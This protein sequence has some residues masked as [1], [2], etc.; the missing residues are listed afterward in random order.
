MKIATFLVLAFGAITGLSI[1]LPDDIPDG[2]FTADFE[3]GNLT[4]VTMLALYEPT[5][6]AGV[7]NAT[8]TLP[9][10]ALPVT[11]ISCNRFWHMD[12]QDY[13]ESLRLI[14]SYCSLGPIIQSYRI[15]GAKVHDT[16]T[17]MCNYGHPIECLSSEVATDMLALDEWCNDHS[18]SG[19][20]FHK[21]VQKTYG[22]SM[23]CQSICGNM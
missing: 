18:V 11:Q 21:S 2:L 23:M 20:V 8:S 15:V 16:V 7:D 17:Y 19:F 22:R 9:E 5:E 13:D 14:E 12:P 10:R 6:P 4:N 3:S 1:Q